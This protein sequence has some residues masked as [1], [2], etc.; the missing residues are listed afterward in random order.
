MIDDAKLTAALKA[1]PTQVQN[2]LG[3][4]G[5]SSVGVTTDDGFARRISELVSQMRVGGTVDLATQ[6]ATAQ[7]SLLQKS[8]DQMTAAPRPRSRRTTRRCTPTWRSTIGKLQSQGSELSA[9]I[10]ALGNYNSN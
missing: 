10:S 9:R 4:V 2:V 3:Q 7:V 1:D 6:G 8:I 5:T